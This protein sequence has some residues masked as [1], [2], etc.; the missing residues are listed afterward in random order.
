MS[1]PNSGPSL[2]FLPGHFFAVD[3]LASSRLQDLNLSLVI[4]TVR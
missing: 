1:L 4:L 2:A 3:V